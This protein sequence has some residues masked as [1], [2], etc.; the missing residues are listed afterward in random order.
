MTPE[1][2]EQVARLYQRALEQDPHA[3]A[4]YVVEACR[5]D[6]DLRREVESLLAQANVSVMV[7]RPVW[8]AAAGLMETSPDLVPGTVI[9]PYRIGAL[10][11]A[12]GMGQVYRAHDTKLQREIALKFLPDA[13]VHDPD[14]LAR[15]TREARVLASLN[16]PHIAAIYGVEDSG[17]MHALVLELVDGPTLADRIACGPVPLD[18]ALTIARQIAEALQAAHEHGIIHRDL[19]PANIKVRDDGTVK[20]LDFGLAKPLAPE[21]VSPAADHPSRSPTITSPAVTGF[22]MILGTAAYMAPE[23]AKGRLADKRSDIWAFGCIL[24]EMLTVTRA[25]GGEDMTDVLGAVVRLEPNWEALPSDLPQAVRTMLHSCLVKDPRHR[26]ADISVALFVLDKA[27]SLALPAP[28]TSARASSRRPLSR[29]L[30]T[31]VAAAFMAS[32]VVGAGTWFVMR[33]GASRVTRTTISTS[34]ATALTVSG[35][36][37]AITPDGSRVIY[38]GN[39]G[40]QLFVRALDALEPV[41]VFTGAP[42][43][44]FVSPDGQWIGFVDGLLVL[45]V[46]VT[47]GPP[48][49]MATLGNASR[50]ATWGPDDTIIV[51]TT[52]GEIGLERVAAAGGPATVLTRPD[53]T[54]GELEHIWP[55]MLPGGRAVLFTITALTGGMDAAQVAVLDL[56]TGRHRVLVRGGSH[57]RYVPS[58]HLVFAAAGT[59]RAVPFDLARLEARGTP[60]PVVPEVVT[61]TIGAVDAAVAGDGTLAYV[62]GGAAALAQRTLVWVDRQGHETRIPAPPRAYV[63]P[64]LSP[65]GTRVALFA[66]DQESD[67][68]A[69]DLSRATLT[70]VTLDP[71][72]DLYPVWTPDGLRVIFTSERTGARTLFSQALDGTGAVERLTESLNIQYASGVSPDGRRLVFTERAPKTGEDVMQLEMDGMHRVTPLVQSPFT[73]RNGIVSPDGRWLAYES[74]DSGRFEISVRPFPEVNSGHWQVSTSGGTRPLWTRSGQE[75]V[76]VSLAGA[77]MRVGVERGPSWAATTPTQLVKEGYRTIAGDNGRTYD[78]APDGQRFL[79]IKEDGGADRTPAPTS[80]IVVQHWGEELKRLVPTK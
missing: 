39:N 61:M 11:G 24:Y 14:R 33:P 26:V 75:L 68:W 42:R 28:T 29:R 30:V 21:A 70:R 6:A 58:G 53:R 35:N 17:S 56:Q 78:I 69:W 43:G 74:N 62:S 71:R 5:D 8:E 50:G 1:R 48:I 63:Y 2:W 18:E 49:T 19:K 67:I 27:T 55:E 41:A 3:R 79:M 66:A 51:A 7:D 73:E 47:G 34:G 25:F 15:F 16:H 32:L 20:V 22:G 77:L 59:L 45:K 52:R 10:L 12:G 38:V 36:D 54:Q 72:S 57:A 23:Q 76:F 65:D 4:A 9:G 80:L 31:P 46:A 44:P 40:T 64:R 60:V 13:F 37:I